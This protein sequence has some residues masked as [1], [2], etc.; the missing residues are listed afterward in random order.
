MRSSREKKRQFY[1]E[2]PNS[3]AE[4]TKE[5][6]GPGMASTDAPRKRSRLF[7]DQ[8]QHQPQ[9]QQQ[10]TYCPNNLGL[11]LPQPAN[12]SPSIHPAFGVSAINLP[13]QISAASGIL[14]TPNPRLDTSHIPRI[15]VGG[16]TVDV[17]NLVIPTNLTPGEFQ[18]RVS[19]MEQEL[20]YQKANPPALPRSDIPELPEKP[21]SEPWRRFPDDVTPEQRQAI[22]AE[23]NRIATTNQR[24]ERE[25][26]NQAAKKSRMKR[27]E[28]LERTRYLLNDRSAECDWWRLKAMSLGASVSEW[29]NLPEEV[30]SSMVNDIKDRVQEID[31][32]MEGDKR[33]EEARRRTA[34][35]KARAALKDNREASLDSSEF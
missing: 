19:E 13:S 26:N 8:Q 10:L 35:N 23:N 34:R 2:S 16:Y 21:P 25:R 1:A 17:A 20:A 27:L 24:I 28:A 7:N 11:A 15:R 4:D 3:D 18:R 32:L 6:P 22:E 33:D 5:S 12:A 14:Q 30:K 31:L 9:Q 29:D